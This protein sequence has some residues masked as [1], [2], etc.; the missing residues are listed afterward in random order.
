VLWLL[1]GVAALWFVLLLAAP[2]LPVP[3]AVSIYAIG[4][5]ICHQRPERSFW[6]AGVQLPVCARCLGIYAGLVAGAAAAPA[7]GLVRRPRLPIV[8]SAVPALASLAVEWSGW[9]AV[10]NGIRAITGLIGGGVIA[11]VVLATLHYERCAP[12]RPNAPTQPPTPI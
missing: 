5:F 7:I 2:L 12:L 6:L 9:G 11:A 3:L 8:L 4:S 10:S 1:G